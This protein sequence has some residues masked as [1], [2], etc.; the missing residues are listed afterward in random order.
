MDTCEIVAISDTFA[1]LPRCFT[2]E[3]L[4]TFIYA[5]EEDQHAILKVIEDDSRFI[6]TNGETAGDKYFIAKNALYRWY[7]RLNLRLAIARKARLSDHKLA[8]LMSSLRL[9]GQWNVPPAEFIEYG[10]SFTLLSPSWNSNEY[11]FP[12]AYVI[13]FRPS[14]GIK[15]ARNILY[16]LNETQELESISDQVVL[17]STEKIL[18]RLSSRESHIIR[19]R[20]GLLNNP[21]MTLE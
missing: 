5:D 13:S 15:V 18:S 11:V 3:E 17:E 19:M 4:L 6:W 9:D 20:E 14:S 1:R 12:L 21:K 10:L 16:S 2:Q 8:L 7:V